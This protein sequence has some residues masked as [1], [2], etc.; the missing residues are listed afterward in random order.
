M[1]F[2]SFCK[3]ILLFIK[4]FKKIRA[5]ITLKIA[6]FSIKVAFLYDEALMQASE[7][8]SPQQAKI[9]ALVMGF[10]ILNFMFV[11]DVK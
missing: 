5:Y 1:Y 4:Y 9:T 7:I 2:D 11:S 3:R 8:I 10:T 6:I